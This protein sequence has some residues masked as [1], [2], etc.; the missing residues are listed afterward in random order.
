MPRQTKARNQQLE[1]LYRKQLAEHEH[2]VSE[3]D[4]MRSELLSRKDELL[5]HGKC[6]DP[7]LKLYIAQMV[8]EAGAVVVPTR[9]MSAYSVY[10]ENRA[11]PFMYDDDDDN[12]ALREQSPAMEMSTISDAPWTRLSNDCE[13]HSLMIN[14]ALPLVASLMEGCLLFILV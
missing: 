8:E 7:P 13:S 5:R 3:R 1:N 2:L 4:R 10:S 12:D 11:Q 9:P 14:Y 6:E